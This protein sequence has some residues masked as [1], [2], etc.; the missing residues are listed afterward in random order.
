RPMIQVLRLEVHRQKNGSRKAVTSDMK[1]SPFAHLSKSLRCKTYSKK[2]GATLTRAMK[3]I[4]KRR[5]LVKM[6]SH[7]Q[8]PFSAPKPL[9]RGSRFRGSWTTS[10][11]FLNANRNRSTEPTA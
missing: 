9:N 11:R 2:Y 6:M 4:Q 1:S 5:L 8:F 7:G 10:S 3:A